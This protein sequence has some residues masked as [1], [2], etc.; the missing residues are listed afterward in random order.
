MVKVKNYWINYGGV[1]DEEDK[2][3]VGKPLDGI[4]SAVPTPQFRGEDFDFDEMWVDPDLK[5]EQEQ[6]QEQEPEEKQQEQAE[7]EEVDLS[8]P[9]LKDDYDSDF[10][11]EEREVDLSSP[12]LKDDY[13]SDFEEEEEVYKAPEAQEEKKEQ[14]NEERFQRIINLAVKG[15]WDDKNIVKKL[16]LQNLKDMLKEYEVQDDCE[17]IDKCL[18]L[19]EKLT[20]KEAQEEKKERESEDD[21][22]SDF[23][24]DEEQEQDTEQEPEQGQAPS[25]RLSEVESESEIPVIDS[26]KISESYDKISSK[27]MEDMY[28]VLKETL[29]ILDELFESGK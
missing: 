18:D 5:L 9:I 2:T 26:S 6:E 17:S 3:N 19:F 1:E 14:E 27:D 24:E 8:S 7:E 25:Q 21:Y 23:E 10:E 16:S 22:D 15:K 28:N 13:D 12:I 11:E 4:E 29:N 20:Q